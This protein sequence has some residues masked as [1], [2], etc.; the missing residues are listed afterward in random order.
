MIFV[1]LF[2]TYFSLY[3]RLWVRPAHCNWLRFIPFC[4]WVIFHCIHV[5][6]GFPGGVSG[7]EPTSQC[8]RHKRHG[9]DLWVRK[10][11]SRR[12]WQLTPVF[13]PRESHEQRS[14]VGY[15]PVGRKELDTT[16]QLSMYT[17]QL[18]S[19]LIC[20]WT[21]AAAAAA[22]SLQSCPTLLCATP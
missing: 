19:P 7:K 6:Q 20:W 12:S 9:L 21:S 8:R 3:N 16:K 22:K 5:P 1:F 11:P 14:L 13:L 15:S 4:C 17:S 18:L 2:L 10:I